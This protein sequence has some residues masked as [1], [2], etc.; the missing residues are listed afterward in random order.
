MTTLGGPAPRGYDRPRR[1]DADTNRGAAGDGST[2][3]AHLFQDEKRRIISSCFSKQ[4]SDGA[5]MLASPSPYTS[6]R[7]ITA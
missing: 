6:V 2:S 4:D 5:C 3:R 7:N 1:S